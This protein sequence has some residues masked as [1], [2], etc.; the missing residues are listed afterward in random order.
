MSAAIDYGENAPNFF[1]YNPVVDE[2]STYLI[3]QSWKCLLDNSAPRFK[4]EHKKYETTA[5]AEFYELFYDNLF[6]M[7]PELEP[8]YRNSIRVKG[9]A[10][11]SMIST[12]L[13]IIRGN[14]KKEMR[15]ELDEIAKMH[16]RLGV[17]PYM[18]GVLGECLIETLGTCLGEEV[19]NEECSQAWIHL[20]SFVVIEVFGVL[21]KVRD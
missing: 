8:I 15:K 12:L 17:I 21:R 18:Y 10:L 19:F 20:Y 7:Q 5:M 1:V 14:D 3:E 2:E 4:E 6:K 16:R 11:V 13:K 9:R